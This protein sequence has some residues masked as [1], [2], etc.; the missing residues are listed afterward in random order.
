MDLILSISG[1]ELIDVLSNSKQLVLADVSPAESFRSGVVA[2]SINLPWNRIGELAERMIPNKKADII[3]FSNT[4]D[5][6]ITIAASAE[7]REMGYSRV[8]FYIRDIK[9]LA[10]VSNRYSRGSRMRR[11]V[12]A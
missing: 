7:L 2:G 8:R 4:R 10:D 6:G 1:E 5:A 9:Y 3:V 12:A 11:N